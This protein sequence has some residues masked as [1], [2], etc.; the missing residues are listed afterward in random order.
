MMDLAWRMTA[1]IDLSF[2]WMEALAAVI[3]ELDVNV[4]VSET[5]A[6]YQI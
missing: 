4:T 2:V 1:I 3:K 6:A 5:M